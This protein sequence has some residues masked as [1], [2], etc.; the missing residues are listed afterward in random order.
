MI[1]QRALQ[2]LQIDQTTN[3]WWERFTPPFKHTNEVFQ[4]FPASLEPRIP[5]IPHCRCVVVFLSV[6][7]RKLAEDLNITL[8][9]IVKS[10][11]QMCHHHKTSKMEDTARTRFWKLYGVHKISSISRKTA[12]I[13]KIIVAVRKPQLRGRA[14]LLT[15]PVSFSTSFSSLE[16]LADF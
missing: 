9:R 5:F 4:M 12:F 11:T 14:V 8:S 13:S 10:N 15:L 2:L 1:L 16:N 6:V 7:V 3:G